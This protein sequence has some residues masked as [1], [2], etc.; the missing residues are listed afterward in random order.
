[1]ELLASESVHDKIDIGP[2]KMVAVRTTKKNRFT[3]WRPKGV[4]LNERVQ[5]RMTRATKNSIIIKVSK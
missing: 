5:K 1:M 3:G 4:L 2:L